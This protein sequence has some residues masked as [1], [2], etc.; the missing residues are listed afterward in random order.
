[1]LEAAQS[2]RYAMLGGQR[3]EAVGKGGESPAAKALGPSHQPGG[4]GQA[5]PD[6]DRGPDPVP[7]KSQLQKP[8]HADQHGEDPDAVQELGPDPAFERSTS[9]LLAAAASSRNKRGRK[10]A[11]AARGQ[12]VPREACSAASREATRADNSASCCR[13]SSS[14]AIAKTLEHFPLLSRYLRVLW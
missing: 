6:P 2:D 1:M 5:D 13:K 14:E 9:P 4:T 8:G 11:S 7:I 3:L 12:A 10:R